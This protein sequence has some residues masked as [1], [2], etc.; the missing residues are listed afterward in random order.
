LV[1]TKEI[2][3]DTL[4]IEKNQKW[5]LGK[6]LKVRVPDDP[7]AMIGLRILDVATFCLGELRQ[8]V[9]FGARW[10]NERRSNFDTGKRRLGRSK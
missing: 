7:S 2:F 6:N 4:Y 5:R 9:R 1:V 3:G 8:Y 10:E